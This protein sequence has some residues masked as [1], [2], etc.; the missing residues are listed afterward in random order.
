M[1]ALQPYASAENVFSSR[2]LP[3]PSQKAVLLG[4]LR[5]NATPSDP[6]Y[7]RSVTTSSRREILRYN[8]DIWTLREAL[9][10]LLAERE[11]FKLHAAQC[12]S[13]FAPIRSLPPEI[14]LKIFAYCSRPWDF[15]P[16]GELSSREHMER[17]AKAPFLELCKVCSVWQS[18]IMETPSLWAAIEINLNEWLLPS[19]ERRAKPLLAVGIERTAACPLRVKVTATAFPYF[20]DSGMVLLGECSR[21][22]QSA[23]LR[24]NSA[25][26]RAISFTRGSFPL[27]EALYIDS[28]SLPEV[29]IF[30]VAPRLREVSLRAYGAIQPPSLP[31][32]QLTTLNYTGDPRDPPGLRPFMGLIHRCTSLTAVKLLI[33]VST[34]SL[35]LAALPPVDTNLTCLAITLRNT[36]D[37]DSIHAT[38]AFTEILGAFTLPSIRKLDLR[39][40]SPRPLVWPL[41]V[42]RAFAARSSLRDTITSLA[43]HG[44]L[45]LDLELLVCIRETPQLES[46]SIADVPSADDESPDHVIV[47]DALLVQL[48]N[49]HLIPHLHVFGMTSLLR[50]TPQTL[51]D[52][53]AFR[54]QS[55]RTPAGPFELEV[56]WN[57][58]LGASPDPELVEQLDALQR[59]RNIAYWMAF[60][61]DAFREKW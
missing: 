59:H 27:L 32:E 43:L 45:I 12:S 42:F 54:I 41:G 18:I 36:H 31:W 50:F 46:L 48:T 17:L 6:S 51:L 20:G 37:S 4:L 58:Q 16:A 44:I 40:N 56:Y 26:F 28:Q 34:L 11:A 5:A 39:M 33:D 14:L 22:W 57:P 2:L 49:A 35:P 10:K 47:S 9:D 60:S 30:E 61:A 38:Q 21:R 24:L 3:D 53:V 23:H 25:A 55:G 7:F 15:R 1:N 52:F 13:L 8:V 29:N 19:V